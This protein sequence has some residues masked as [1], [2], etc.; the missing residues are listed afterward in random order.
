MHTRDTQS[1]ADTNAFIQ[2]ETV[3]LYDRY[4]ESNAL[5]WAARRTCSALDLGAAHNHPPGYLGVD[6]FPAE[7]VDILGDTSPIVCLQAT[8]ASG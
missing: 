7:G 6:Q 4:I 5:A 8:A 2:R 1:D 3:A